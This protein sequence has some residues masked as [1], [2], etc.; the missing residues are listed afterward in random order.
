MKDESGRVLSTLRLSFNPFLRLIS[1]V[2]FLIYLCLSVIQSL[3]I[4]SS[5]PLPGRGLRKK[6]VCKYNR[7]RNTTGD[8][9]Q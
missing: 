6:Y 3:S 9:I 8:T 2:S 4:S 5:L 7:G 1:S